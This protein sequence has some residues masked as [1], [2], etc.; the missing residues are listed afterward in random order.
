MRAARNT[1]LNVNVIN[2]AS[3]VILKACNTLTPKPLINLVTTT[4]QLMMLTWLMTC[5]IAI[6]RVNLSLNLNLS[7]WCNRQWTGRLMPITYG[8]TLQ[9][10]QAIVWYRPQKLTAIT[11]AIITLI[12]C[13][14]HSIT[15]HRWLTLATKHQLSSAQMPICLYHSRKRL[16]KMLTRL[17]WPLRVTTRATLTCI[18]SC[19]RTRL[20]SLTVTVIIPSTTLQK[21]IQVPLE[22]GRTM[23]RCW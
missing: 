7:L 18:W 16:M 10:I 5:V 8:T 22:M 19:L 3:L 12:T 1:S 11:I 13:G 17:M 9:S 20:I 4:S 2:R 21:M 15:R 14:A 23:T 6:Y